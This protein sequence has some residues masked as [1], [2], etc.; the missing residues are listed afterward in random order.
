MIEI[1]KGNGVRHWSPPLLSDYSRKVGG[2]KPNLCDKS[3][4][5]FFNSAKRRP[6]MPRALLAEAAYSGHRG[7]F[8]GPLMDGAALSLDNGI[9]TH[10]IT[11]RPPR[12]TEAAFK[13]G[14]G[15]VL[16][17]SGMP[18]PLMFGR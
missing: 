15:W 4:E 10:L 7:I 13:S 2:D 18:L 8:L 17:A 12:V 1:R 11:K 14:K 5:E 9:V 3:A 6:S 16:G